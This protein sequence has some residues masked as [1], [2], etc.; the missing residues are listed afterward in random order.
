MFNPQM[1]QNFN[2]MKQD[3]KIVQDRVYQSTFYGQSGGSVVKVSIKGNK[4]VLSVD[5]D[6][7]KVDVEDFDLIGDMVVAAMNDAI[8]KAD[9]ELQSAI[10]S[11]TQGMSIPGLF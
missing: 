1:M 7:E 2:K 8:K 6:K 10:E 5:I 4:Q 3:L 9:S 11:V